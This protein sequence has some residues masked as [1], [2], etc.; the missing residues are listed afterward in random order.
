[1]QLANPNT[2]TTI[3]LNLCH[4]IIS[5]K[6]LDIKFDLGQKIYNVKESIE[7]RYGTKPDSCELV[8]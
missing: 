2:N 8:L 1:M 4:N 6:M 7:K 3:K 5:N